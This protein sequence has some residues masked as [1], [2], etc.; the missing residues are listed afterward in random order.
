MKTIIVPVNFSASSDNAARYAADMALAIHADLHLIHFVQIQASTS[1][2]PL[3]GYALAELQESGKEGLQQLRDALIKRTE[4]KVNIFTYMEV[5]PVED[6]IEEYCAKKMP[7]IVI[8]GNAGK[9]LERAL[10]GSNVSQ[11]IRH[12][13]HPMIVVPENAV[14]HSIKKI[15]L[16]CDL[17]DIAEGVPVSVSFLKEFRHIFGAGFEVINIATGRQDHQEEAEAAFVFNSWKDRLLEIYP[18]VHFLRMNKVEDGI[19]E[20][21]SNHPAD[22]L[23]VFPKKHNVFEFHKSHAKK[24]AFNSSIPVMS[25]H[26]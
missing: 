20:Y 2:V 1:D 23:L 10:T 21:L 14:F 3:A 26:A 11:A 9:S 22:L 13:P 6:R 25:I 12:L 8:M 7:F 24:I 17:D 16:A 18:E 5:G 4:G 15:V 19:S